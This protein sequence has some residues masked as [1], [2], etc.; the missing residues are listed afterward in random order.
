MEEPET[1]PETPASGEVAEEGETGFDLPKLSKKEKKKRA[2]AAAQ[3][4]GSISDDIA[5]AEEK[6]VERE[7]EREIVEEPESYIETPKKSKSKKNKKG[8]INWEDTGAADRGDAFIDPQNEVVSATPQDIEVDLPKKSKESRNQRESE[9]FEDAILSETAK[10]DKD[11]LKPLDESSDREIDEFY[12]A[13]PDVSGSVTSPKAAKIDYETQLDETSRFEGTYNVDSPAPAAPVL[14]EPV[15]ESK[16]SKKKK[17]KS[18]GGIFGFFSRSEPDVESDDPE[19]NADKSEMLENGSKSMPDTSEIST[20]NDLTN[21]SNG[22]GHD[23]NDDND[24]PQNDDIKDKSFLDNAGTLGA[25]VG[26]AA[27]ATAHRLFENASNAN[28]DEATEQLHGGSSERGVLEEGSKAPFS[29]IENEAIDPE[30]TERQFRPSIDPQYGDLLPL[31]PSDPSTPLPIL[32]DLPELPESRSG[33]P[34]DERLAM[35]EK[36]R[37]SIHQ[38]VVKSP[39]Q[40]AVPLKFFML[41]GQRLHHRPT[42]D[43]H[44]SLPVLR[45]MRSRQGFRVLDHDQCLGRMLPMNINPFI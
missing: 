12:D 28:N 2:K 23:T 1:L 10:H 20:V 15:E 4:Q 35:R 24:T 45:L 30:I 8:S 3:Q 21:L 19:S 38:S 42:L 39:S 18:S 33:T 41:T 40:S 16:S 7:P 9:Q 6:P 44:P 5:V 25:G 27:A 22:H 26:F 34:E 17:K 43:H 32:E 13:N 31:P 11:D 29:E 37:K 14:P 36:A